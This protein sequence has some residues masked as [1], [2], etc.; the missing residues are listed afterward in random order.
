MSIVL[1]CGKLGELFEVVGAVG[2]ASRG[3]KNAVARVVW[4]TGTLEDAL[5]WG[6]CRPFGES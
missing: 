5:P 1:K 2:D 3:V 4:Q 6:P